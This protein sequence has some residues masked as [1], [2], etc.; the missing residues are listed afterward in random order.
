[1]V[2]GIITGGYLLPVTAENVIKEKQ[3]KCM[4][5]YIFFTY[6]FL[7]RIDMSSLGKNLYMID[8]LERCDGFHIQWDKEIFF[9]RVSELGY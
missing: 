5:E 2:F 6:D 8:W 3:M 9:D 1:M 4:D 7:Q